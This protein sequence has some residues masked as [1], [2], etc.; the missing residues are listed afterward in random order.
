MTNEPGLTLRDYC[1]VIQTAIK[2]V[3]ESRQS[4]TPTDVILSIPTLQQIEDTVIAKYLVDKIA[5]EK[6]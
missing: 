3:I 5:E 2:T 4:L 1:K 6:K